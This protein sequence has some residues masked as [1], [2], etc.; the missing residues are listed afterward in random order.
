[1]RWPRSS[2]RSGSTTCSSNGKCRKSSLVYVD[3]KKQRPPEGGLAPY[4]RRGRG[5]EACAW[6]VSLLPR[7]V[8]FKKGALASLGL[9]SGGGLPQAMM[10]RRQVAPEEDAP[11]YYG[12]AHLLPNSQE[13]HHD[14][15]KSERVETGTGA[16]ADHAGGDRAAA[17]GR[18]EPLEPVALQPH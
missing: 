14:G 7:A 18:A 6:S 4:P 11:C 9:P 10:H 5:G 12:R 13:G 1:T 15:R 3:M 8:R 17:G 2:P 16:G